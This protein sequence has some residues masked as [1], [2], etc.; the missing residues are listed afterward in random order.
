MILPMKIYIVEEEYPG[1]KVVTIERSD[2]FATEEGATAHL[3]CLQREYVR[4]LKERIQTAEKQIEASLR[5]LMQ[6]QA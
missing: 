1:H 6:K 4:G 2:W 5:T 3:I